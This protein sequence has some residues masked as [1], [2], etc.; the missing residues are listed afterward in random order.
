MFGCG[1]VMAPSRT[2]FLTVVAVVW[3]LFSAGA[4]M[5]QSPDLPFSAGI[6]VNKA[7]QFMAKEKFGEAVAE[8]KAF[9]A[10]KASVSPE[11]AAKKGY[12][13]YYIDFMIANGLLMM[14]QKNSNP[15]YVKEAAARLAAVVKK[16]PDLYPAWVNLARCRYELGQM[17]LAG[18]C[19]LK[20]YDTGEE[21]NPQ[22]LYYAVICQ[23]TAEKHQKA[24]DIFYRLLKAHPGDVRLEWKETLVHILFALEKN[25]Q[26]LPYI[27]ELAQKNTGDK[28][29]KWQEIL[30]NQ[31]MLL[32]MDKE[33]L[34]YAR[35][36]TRLEP[37]EPKWWKALTHIYLGVNQLE[38]GLSSLLIYSYLVPLSE[39]E[40]SL[41]AD[42]YMACGIPTQAAVYYQ[43]RLE[44]QKEAGEKFKTIKQISQAFLNGGEKESALKWIDKG[45]SAGK[46]PALLKMKADILFAEKAY[47]KALDVYAQLEKFKS[48]RGQALLMQ[49]Y[50]AWNLDNLKLAEQAFAGASEYSQQKKA[51]QNALTQIR[52]TPGHSA[53]VSN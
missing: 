37:E 27:K 30:L 12:D 51:A 7:N 47:A 1:R 22:H 29:K 3:A 19:F 38:P 21:K 23:T 33:A 9:S 8:L 28:R 43:A 6:C 50:A 39:R 52:R 36:L 49:G 16:K 4:A 34:A 44:Q 45:L 35:S 10:Q 25:E 53:A 46:D 48:F 17:A 11:E 20:A 18:D 2:I 41:L 40:T 14:D 26:A 42:L 32:K 15:A 5:A 13:H 31:Y 24:L